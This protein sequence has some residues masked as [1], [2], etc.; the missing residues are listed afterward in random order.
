MNTSAIGHLPH[1]DAALSYIEPT[2]GK[3]RSLEYE[4]PPG[5]PRSTL[6]YRDHT[7]AIHDVRPVTSAV[8]LERE[9]FQLVTAASRID[10]F[11]DSDAIRRRYYAEAVSLLEE[12]T[13]ASRVVVFDHT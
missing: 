6:A 5:V 9:G 13:G 2:G 10:D 1:V 3:P 11:S 12:L 8:S 7:V 4:P